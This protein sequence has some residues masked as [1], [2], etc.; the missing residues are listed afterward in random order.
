MLLWFVPT[1]IT[2]GILN[3]TSWL[4]IKKM[5]FLKTTWILPRGFLWIVGS[6]KNSCHRRK[7]RGGTFRKHMKHSEWLEL[8]L[9]FINPP[10]DMVLCFSYGSPRALEQC[11]M[12]GRQML[13]NGKLVDWLADGQ[14]SWLSPTTGLPSWADFHFSCWRSGDVPW[15]TE[16]GALVSQRNKNE[17]VSYLCWQVGKLQWQNENKTN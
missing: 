7:E 14:T 6:I 5:E 17:T 4:I 3:L 9:A 12:N 8:A 16:R 13:R 1:Y 10:T 2:E 15:Q 11:L